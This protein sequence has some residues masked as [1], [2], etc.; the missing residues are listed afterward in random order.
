MRRL[1]WYPDSRIVAVCPCLPQIH[2]WRSGRLPAYSGA[3][4]PAFD[5]LPS[6]KRERAWIRDAGER[7]WFPNAASAMKAAF[8]AA[9]AAFALTAC[10]PH[11]AP[12]HGVAQPARR[13]VSLMPSLTDD[14]CAVGAG[15]QIIAVSQYTDA[16][17]AKALPA[18]GNFSSVDTERIVQLHPDVVIG[19]PAQRLM[20]SGVRRAGIPTL[21]FKDDSLEDLYGDIGA[22]GRISGHETAASALLQ[23]LKARTATLSASA[24]FPRRPS[25]FFVEQAL[26]IW[27]AGPQSYISQLI[28]LAG[29]RNA[30]QSL[31]QPYA[32]FSPEVLVRLQ[33][34][35]IVATDDAHLDSVLQRE[36]WR[37]LKAV[38]SGHVF[39][40]ANADILSRPGPRYNEGIAWL[41][42]RL[43]PIAAK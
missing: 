43:R 3:T 21:F 18:V 2:E 28:T 11:A 35:A 38:R 42:A 32:Q 22:A 30:V 40:L 24:R 25:V 20:T 23:T 29:G 34:D 6:R 33:P 41:I 13:I 15:K 26:P 10:A 14:L 1:R 12:Q 9:V 16:P 36:P 8:V 39:V 19:I 17:C 27:T 7:S 37:S 4:V 31:A 5:R